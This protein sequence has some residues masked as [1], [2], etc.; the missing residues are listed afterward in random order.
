M[1][2]HTDVALTKS[3]TNEHTIV[4]TDASALTNDTYITVGGITNKISEFVRAGVV[5]RTS[6]GHSIA[7]EN[8]PYMLSVAHVYA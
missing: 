3:S 8:D 7:V 6:N 4:A 5:R 1:S 2:K